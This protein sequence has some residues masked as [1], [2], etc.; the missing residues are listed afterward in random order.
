[1]LYTAIHLLQSQNV[2]REK[3]RKSLLYQKF[4]RKMLMK[5]T[6][7]GDSSNN[8]MDRLFLSCWRTFGARTWYGNRISRRNYLACPSI[9]CQTAR[10]NKLDIITFE[11]EA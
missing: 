8:V 3:L 7:D 10:I 9:D 5:L 11:D 2:S 1:V 6:P 4:A